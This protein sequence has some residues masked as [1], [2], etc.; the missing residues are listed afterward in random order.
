M[1]NSFLYSHQHANNSGS[2]I[3][4]VLF[5]LAAFLLHHDLIHKMHERTIAINTK[6]NMQILLH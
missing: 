4:V 2:L 5:P 3:D 6:A 1:A